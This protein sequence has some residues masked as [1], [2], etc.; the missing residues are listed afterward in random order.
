MGLLK[1][2]PPRHS[3]N[4]PS[5][6]VQDLIGIGTQVLK[7]LKT[8]VIMGPIILAQFA[9]DNYFTLNMLFG[10]PKPDGFTRTILNSSDKKGLNH[11]VKD[12]LTPDLCTVQYAQFKEV[13][14]IVKALGKNAWL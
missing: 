3:N 4:N 12:L 5:F 1:N 10:M 14:E 11:S 6:S 2:C 13:L 7:W 9:V 8:G